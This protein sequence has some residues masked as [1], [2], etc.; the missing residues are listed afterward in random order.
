MMYVKRKVNFTA[1]SETNY[2]FQK[3]MYNVPTL[4]THSFAVIQHGI[5]AVHQQPNESSIA[6]VNDHVR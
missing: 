3:R 4:L 5:D 1:L 2:A 6:I